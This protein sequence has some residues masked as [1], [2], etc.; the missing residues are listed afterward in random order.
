MINLF[1]YFF[2]K[3]ISVLIALSVVVTAIFA[4]VIGT[5][6]L[7]IYRYD[8]ALS[9]D[10]LVPEANPSQLIVYLVVIFLLSFLVPFSEFSFKMKKRGI[11]QMYSLP[12]K[13]EKLYFVKFLICLC[14][15]IIPFIIGG[16]ISI[17]VIMGKDH[18]YNLGMFIPY[19]L[20]LIACSIGVTIISSCVFI[21]QNT[22]I[23]GAVIAIF[24][25]FILSTVITSI[26]MI[27]YKIFGYD[28]NDVDASKYLLFSP[29]IS[30]Y[31]GMASLIANREINYLTWEG[32][33][34]VAI[35]VFVLISIGAT[36]LSYFHIKNEKSENSQ[37]ISSSL[38]GYSLYIPLLAISISIIVNEINVLLF[39]FQIAIYL[40]Y[41]LYLRKF[42]LDKKHAFIASIVILVSL[43]TGLCLHAL[44]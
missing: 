20:S 13:R 30:I 12:I 40:T 28:M 38:L 25:I 36:I 5:S 32:G 14:E 29:L 43:V 35:I 15:I 18:L 3:R 22:E 41:V 8:G 37:Q 9:Q 33:D 4:I 26:R 27:L 16:V 1:K 6:R 31:K 11:D 42:K 21:H 17:F 7:I 39:L 10:S 23:D 44:N 2:K 34:T 24:T 19:F